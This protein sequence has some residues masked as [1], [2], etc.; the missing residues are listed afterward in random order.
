VG[1]G[2]RRCGGRSSETFRSPPLQISVLELSTSPGI[3]KIGNGHGHLLPIELLLAEIQSTAQ[4]EHRSVD[5]V[6]TDAVKR[7]LEE[8]L[9][10]KL[11]GY[12][13]EKAKALDIME[14]DVD[15]LISESRAKQRH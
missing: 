14:S 3:G 2:G 10:T 13:A 11:L 5:E 1:T 9:W 7:Y 4:A 6:L 8:R 12:G 15:R